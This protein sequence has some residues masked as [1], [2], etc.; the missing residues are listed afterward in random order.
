MY[1]NRQ[2][3][4]TRRFA[5]GLPPPIPNTPATYVLL[6]P[7]E[8][9]EVRAIVRRFVFVVHSVFFVRANL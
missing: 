8:R 3:T 4:L 7:G 2:E 9:I 1:G 5:Y 6:S